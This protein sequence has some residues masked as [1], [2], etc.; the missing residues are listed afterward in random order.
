[1]EKDKIEELYA[2]YKEMLKEAFT[3]FTKNLDED[4]QLNDTLKASFLF[5]G[6]YSLFAPAICGYFLLHG[7][8]QEESTDLTNKFNQVFLGEM[9]R[10]CNQSIEKI[11][12]GNKSIIIGVKK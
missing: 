6:T 5:D 11:K 1:M 8:T 10:F 7:L 4:K 3:A 2:P 12:K 9:I